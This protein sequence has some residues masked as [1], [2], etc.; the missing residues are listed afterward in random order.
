MLKVHMMGHV[1]I[2]VTF[3]GPKTDGRPGCWNTFLLSVVTS[4]LETGHS[5]L[6][7]IIADIL[8][9]LCMCIQKQKSET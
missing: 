3:R 2:S 4:A 5:T 1:T 6:S 8:L 7:T 9:A